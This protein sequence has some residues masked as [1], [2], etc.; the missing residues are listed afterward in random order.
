MALE[1]G[2]FISQVTQLRSLLVIVQLLGD[3]RYV[4]ELLL[5]SQASKL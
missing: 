3:T 4:I 5:A 1:G 2:Y